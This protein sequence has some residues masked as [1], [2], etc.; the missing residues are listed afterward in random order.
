MWDFWEVI[1]FF[2]LQRQRRHCRGVERVHGCVCDRERKLSVRVCL[3]RASGRVWVTIC[4]LLLL[5]VNFVLLFL[6]LVLLFLFCFAFE[7]RYFKAAVQSVLAVCVC[8]PLCVV[9]VSEGTALVA[10]CLSLFLDKGSK[11]EQQCTGCRAACLPL[12][13]P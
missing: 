11:G 6:N 1:H 9:M 12:S 10:L 3:K 8:V 2:L 7:R 4:L 5:P 13:L